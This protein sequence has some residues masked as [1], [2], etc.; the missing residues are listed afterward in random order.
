MI[1]PGEFIPIAEECKLIVPLGE[2]ILRTAMAE[3]ANWP[4]DV[5]VSINLSPVQFRNRRLLSV[6]V[7]A[8]SESGLTPNRLQVEITET[9][10]MD[11]GE[12]TLAMLRDLRAL[13]VRVALDDFGTGYSSLNYLRRFPFDKIKIDKSFVDDIHSDAQSRAIV[14]AIM[15]LTTAL[16]MTTVAEGVEKLSQLF[17]LRALGCDEVQ[18][19]VISAAIDASSIPDY[20]GFDLGDLTAD[21]VEPSDLELVEGDG[22]AVA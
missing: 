4:K 21:L 13:G 8:L 22:R 3:A 7:D 2:W 12:A 19:Y 20:L 6:I 16:G 15:E 10:L 11:D 18:G 9:A 17:E 14:R 5:R 1:S